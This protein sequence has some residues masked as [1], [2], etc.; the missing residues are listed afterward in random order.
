M[1]GTFN[2][3][4][5]T[6][7][8]TDYTPSITTEVSRYWFVK[9]TDVDKEYLGYAVRDYNSTQRTNRL[10]IITHT[11]LPDSLKRN[12][13]NVEILNPWDK[14]KIDSFASS[15]K[16]FQSFDFCPVKRSDSELIWNFI[17]T[18][19]F[20]NR[21]VLDIGCNTGYFSFK[22]SQKGG[23]VI[24][25]EPNKKTLETAK[26]IRDYI[27]QQDVE[28]VNKMPEGKFDIIFYLSVHHQPDPEYK[29]LNKTIRQLKKRAKK[30][31]FV[32]LIMPPMFPIGR[33]MSEEKI[34]S[35]VGG[36]ILKRYKHNVRGDRK[37][38]WVQK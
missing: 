38:Y 13:I 26:T 21:S 27:I 8:I 15:V 4:I 29:N 32:E 35:I 20:K 22:A 19:D 10:E 5:P 25:F 36:Q 30:H 7:R 16:W 2:I 31:L 18:V 33:D 28:F 12:N 11:L 17:N 34:D 23:K 37:I 24:G 3:D 6:F 1:Y 9:I 14:E